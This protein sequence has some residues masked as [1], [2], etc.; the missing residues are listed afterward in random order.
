M[1]VM[2]WRLERGANVGADGAVSFAVWAPR[3]RALSVRIVGAGGETRAEIPMDRDGDGVF[4]ARVDAAVAAPGSDYAYV[5]P[6]VGARPDP[7]SRHQPNG[8]HAPSRIVAPADSFAW[9]DD[10]WRGVPRADLVI[11]ELH[12]G[13]FS[14]EGTFAGVAA[15]LPYLRDLGVTAVELMPVAAFPGD[16]NWGYDGVYLYAPHTAYGGPDGLRRLADACHAHGLALIID[17]VYNHLGPEGNYLGD[18]GPYFTNRYRTPWGDALNFDGPESDQVRRFFVDNALTWLTEYHA[19]GLRLDAI[20]GIH[21]FSA[22]PILQEIADAFR[23]EAARLGRDA[24][25]IAESD[26]NDPRVIRPK[27]VG[28]LGLDAQW[29]DDFHH[30]LH[31]IVTGNRRGYFADFGRVA[32]I[33]KAITASFVYDGQHA[34][35]RRRRHG[36]PAVGDMGDRFVSFIQNHDQV[37][38][39]YQ[40]Q[41]LAQVAG[42]ARQKVAATVLFSTPALPLL[43]QGEEYAEA[44][45]FD[46]FTSHGDEALAKAVREGRHA[47]Y[48][49]LLDEGADMGAWADPQAEKTFLA[50]K[51][52]WASIDRA[53]HADM[54]AF[55]R[56]LIAARARLAPLRN[57]R[58]DLARVEHDEA[59]RWLTI[60]RSD[61]GGA[62]TFTCA[63]LG[64]A[65]ARIRLPPGTWRLVLATEAAASPDDV[66]AGALLL[67]PSAAAIYELVPT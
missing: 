62:A 44:A 48:L 31:A 37:A 46:Y 33:G 59:G 15:R 5:L 6:D 20:Q 30:A 4:T 19:D 43:F 3:R 21:D 26:L 24:W 52:R 38:N 34:P 65:P 56:D 9:T 23:A 63:N 32:D 13:T 42:H 45:P 29:S 47:E 39:A 16:R 36:A 61:V 51:L 60:M 66:A 57:G 1:P 18:Y 22:R 17:V 28:G 55:Y 54:L 10:A 49:H 11:Y 25:L 8:V 27:E 50:C 12:V 40:G 53:P 41:R 64:D 67:P 58:K 35:H 14:P 7:V 2:T